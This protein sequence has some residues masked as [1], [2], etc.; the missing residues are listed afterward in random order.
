MDQ[1]SVLQR[2][3]RCFLDTLICRRLFI[4]QDLR[5]MLTSD[6]TEGLKPVTKNYCRAQITKTWLIYNH[7]SL[8]DTSFSFN[9]QLLLGN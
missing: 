3:E 9:G 2:E 6:W 7:V 8:S 1:I 4:H 5:E